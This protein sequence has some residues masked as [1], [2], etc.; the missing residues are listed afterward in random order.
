VAAT[1]ENDHSSLEVYLYDHK[2]SDLYVHHEILL[3][4]YPLCLQW[5]S[6][7]QSKKTNH[8]IV[9]TFLPEIEIWNL[10]SEAVEP[11]ALLGSLEKSEQF[12]AGQYKGG[13]DIG[14]HT[15]AVM[16]LS[17]NPM[18][19]EYLASGS[20]D[21]T[22][23]IWDLDDL[24][25]KCKFD[26]HKDKVQ[27]VKWNAI[28]ES[29]LMS[30]GYDHKVNVIDVR[31]QAKN[32]TI[33]VPKAVKDIESGSWHP[34]LEHNF[35]LATESGVVLGYDIRKP[36]APL[37]ELASTDESCSGLGFSPHIPTMMCTSSTDGVVRIW[38]IGGASPME[39]A[40]K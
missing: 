39:I 13:D 2:S 31:D 21:H 27:V 37:W 22:V 29:I 4:S 20:E 17:L 34:S 1:A 36:Q 40:Q 32:I 24:Q 26:Y 7:W 14:T 16:C 3:G 33:K 6:H 8:I 19:K 28:N 5:L 35:A 23:R 18:Q 15:E 25:C 12:K 38:D 9:G 30:A 11:A 10:D